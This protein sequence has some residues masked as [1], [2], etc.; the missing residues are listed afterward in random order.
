MRG[1][2]IFFLL[3]T[4][5]HFNLKLKT[6]LHHCQHTQTH[7]LIPTNTFKTLVVMCFLFHFLLF[8]SFYHSHALS[9]FF[10][11]LSFTALL[12]FIISLLFSSLFCFSH[13]LPL[14]LLLSHHAAFL[15][16]LRLAV[17]IFQSFISPNVRHRFCP[18]S[19]EKKRWKERWRNGE[20]T[21]KI[22]GSKERRNG[23]EDKK[24]RIKCGINLAIWMHSLS[25]LLLYAYSW[26]FQADRLCKF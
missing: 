14:F 20:M 7:T 13:K 16:S 17:F 19:R 8:S 15:S 24:L 26:I 10:C 3:S 6:W 11:S 18:P 9:S 21:T 4:I 1:R 25:S 23:I 22:M 5:R 12:F 2:L